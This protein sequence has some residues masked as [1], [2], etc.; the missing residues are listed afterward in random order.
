MAFPKWM[1]KSAGLARGWKCQYV[2]CTRTYADGWL[3]ECHHILPT[4][5]GGQDT[6]DNMIIVCIEHHMILH[7]QLFETGFGHP[8][9]ARLVRTR[10]ENTGGRY[11]P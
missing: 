4:Q 2:G 8:E 7:E 5:N 6:F 10:L 1:R 3:M 11:R 9:S